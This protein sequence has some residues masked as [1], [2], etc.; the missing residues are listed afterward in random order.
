MLSTIAS[1][2]SPHKSYT[3]R[4]IIFDLVLDGLEFGLN[5]FELRTTGLRGSYV[6]VQKNFSNWLRGKEK[7][8][9]IKN[10]SGIG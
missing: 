5:W 1:L 2:C 10:S 6:Y 8:R 9:S 7:K 4:A 3:Y